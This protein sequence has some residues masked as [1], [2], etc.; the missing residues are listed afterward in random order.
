VPLFHR[1]SRGVTLTSAGSQLLPRG[2][3]PRLTV[4]C[5]EYN[6]CRRHIVRL[7]PYLACLSLRPRS[8]WLPKFPA[9]QPESVARSRSSLG[10]GRQ[11]CLYRQRLLPHAVF[12]P[13]R[14]TAA[15]PSCARRSRLKTFCTILSRRRRADLQLRWV[16]ACPPLSWTRSVRLGKD[17]Y[18]ARR[19]GS[20]ANPRCHSSGFAGSDCSSQSYN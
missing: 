15:I 17:S 16:T 14:T 4:D 1:H 10:R 9:A 8:P 12:S 6:D 11:R 3:E 20:R 19:N 7:R 5:A 18:A 13:T 2:C